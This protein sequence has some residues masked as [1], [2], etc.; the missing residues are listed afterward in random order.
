MVDGLDHR[1]SHTVDN[2]LQIGT[3]ANVRNASEEFGSVELLSTRSCTLPSSE[4]DSCSDHSLQS[5]DRTQH[6]ALD[7]PRMKTRTNHTHDASPRGVAS[8]HPKSECYIHSK[9][10]AWP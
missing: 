1:V 7:Y 5:H 2:A 10:H 4:G 6:L 8:T 3:G 9:Y